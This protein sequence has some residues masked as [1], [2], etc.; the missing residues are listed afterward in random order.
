VVLGISGIARISSLVQ[1]CLD[2]Q[3]AHAVG[4][5]GAADRGVALDEQRLAAGATPA[6]LPPSGQEPRR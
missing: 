2:H 4:G 1:R 6:A 3:A 5:S